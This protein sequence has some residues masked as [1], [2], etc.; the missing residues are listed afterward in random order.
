M[1]A[2]FDILLAVG[3]LNYTI[4]SYIM[5]QG[6]VPLHAMASGGLG[7]VALVQMSWLSEDSKVTRC[8]RLFVTICE[9]LG[10]LVLFVALLQAAQTLVVEE[11]A[12]LE[13]LRAEEE[14]EKHVLWTKITEHIISEVAE[15]VAIFRSI[16]ETPEILTSSGSIALLTCA[17]FTASLFYGY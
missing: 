2:I 12:L 11:L 16:L 17:C 4:Y 7:F 1:V 13:Q 10:S 15:E 8:A 14:V 6:L 9:A 5:R 3:A